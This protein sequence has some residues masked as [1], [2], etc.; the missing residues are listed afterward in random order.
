MKKFVFDYE[1]NQETLDLFY[2]QFFSRDNMCQ[3][4]ENSIIIFLC[5]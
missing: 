4:L 3:D 2:S 1:S 5:K